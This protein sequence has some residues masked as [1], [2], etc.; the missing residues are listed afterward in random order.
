M[1]AHVRTGHFTLLGTRL[2]VDKLFVFPSQKRKR[3]SAAM[4]DKSNIRREVPDTGP[5]I[6]V[7]LEGFT[8]M[9]ANILFGL[10]NHHRHNQQ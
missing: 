1:I 4:H 7:L 6:F 9:V 5:S 8:S 10:H 2:K 3:A